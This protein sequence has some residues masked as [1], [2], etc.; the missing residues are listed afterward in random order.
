MESGSWENRGAGVNMMDSGDS[1]SARN[2]GCGNPAQWFS[3]LQSYRQVRKDENPPVAHWPQQ[4]ECS[5]VD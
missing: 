3:L 5:A 2:L 1:Q 4:T